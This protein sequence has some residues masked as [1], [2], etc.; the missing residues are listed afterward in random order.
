M[1]SLGLFNNDYAAKICI[2]QGHLNSG[3]R[4]IRWARLPPDRHHQLFSSFEWFKTLCH[5]MSNFTI[6]FSAF[7]TFLS[8]LK[9]FFLVK[10]SVVWIHY[11][12]QWNVFSCRV[13]AYANLTRYRFYHSSL[14]VPAFWFQQIDVNGCQGVV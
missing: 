14:A 9:D 1:L 6:K 13:I 2:L 12:T 5:I 8:V 4:N 10:K 11:W 7:I 3:R